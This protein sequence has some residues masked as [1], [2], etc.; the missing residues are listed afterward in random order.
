MLTQ[1]LLGLTVI[2]ALATVVTALTKRTY[3]AA[4][5]LLAA[6]LLCFA[7]LCFFELRL[8][9]EPEQ[10][11]ACYR[12]IL[13]LHIGTT[14][15]CYYYTK[16]IFRDNSEIYRGPGFWIS[17]ATALTTVVF[18]SIIPLE[19]LIFSP[20]FSEEQLIYLTKSGFAVYL[21]LM[22]YLVFGLVQLE[23]TL[24]G[25]HQLQRWRVKI[26]V[27]GSGLFLASFAL[28]FS[29]T[30]L[31]RSLNMNYLSWRCVA[32]AVALSILCYG[33]LFRGGESRLA[34]S[35]G[36]AHRSFVLL[37]VGG[38]LI[39][40]GLLGEGL[41][42]LNM[43]NIKPVIYALLLAGGLGLAVIFLSEKLRRKLKVTLHKNFY[44]SK[45]DYRRQW[46]E[47]ALCV[48]GGKNLAEIQQAVLD[49][50]CQNLAC[51]GASLYLVDN[52]AGGE[53]HFASAFSM[54][55][56]WRPFTA[57]DALVATLGQREW[58]I[59]LRERHDFHA[60]LISSFSS[61]DAFLVIPLIL[62]SE[63]LGFIIL[64]EQINRG[65]ELTY[66]DYDLMR[67]LARQTIAT[68]QSMRLNE[69]L[70]TARE[71]AALGK[72]STFVLHDLKNQVS[73][74]SLMLDNARDYIAD[75]EFQDDMLETIETTVKNMKGLIARLK[76]VKEKP[77]LATKAVQLGAIVEDAVET[78]GGRINV[79][80]DPVRVS[81]DEEEIYKVILNLLVN[82]QEASG[83]Q[84]PVSVTFG[85]AA[86]RAWVRVADQGC[87][88][89][90][91]FIREQLFKPFVTTKEHG[92]GIGLYQCRQIVEAH[93]GSIE[94]E[95][96][97]GEGTTFTLWLPKDIET[98]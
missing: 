43:D 96:R 98:T 76:N 37:I 74:L 83:Y 5:L 13:L 80:G 36:I 60:S 48:S 10:L 47:F 55:R 3:P 45:Y 94:V 19:K 16:T 12:V 90:D 82:A 84:E 11:F 93:G 92:F 15:G 42:Y 18:A 30:L 71:L 79:A 51:K 6:G 34:L 70:S 39:I 73:G 78:A 41:R 22:L 77:Q 97:V 23:R 1:I 29:H 27:I 59:N 35:R 72:L 26:E 88:M 8:L 56:D 9:G 25:L 64:A 87:G 75:P 44:Q 50:F 61:H 49:L 21:V 63:L 20:D 54:R 28:F 95:S 81:V 69:Q 52:D 4:T 24:S 32:A 66:E 7:A 33:R 62:D 58:I 86:A 67:M 46:E 38:Y 40:L 57:D 65:E 53:Y 31:Y 2:L 17:V 85:A 14:F 91:E 68:I 89:T